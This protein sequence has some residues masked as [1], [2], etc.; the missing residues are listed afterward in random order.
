MGP[1]ML[2]RFFMM[3]LF[4]VSVVHVVMRGFIAMIL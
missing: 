4:V 2:L 3:W 1:M